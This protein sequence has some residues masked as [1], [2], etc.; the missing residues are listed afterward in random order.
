MYHEDT[1]TSIAADL[2]ACSY[3]LVYAALLTLQ[4]TSR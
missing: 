3:R 2:D 1:I 4:Q